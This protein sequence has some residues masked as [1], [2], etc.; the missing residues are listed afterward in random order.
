[1]VISQSAA[2]RFFP[3]EDPVGQ[4][5][6]TGGCTECPWTT[7]VGVVG[8]VKDRGLSNGDTP[9]MYVPFVQEP[10]RSMYL[11]VRTEVEPTSLVPAIRREVNAVDRDLALADIRTMD[12]LVSESL[13]QSRYRVVLLGIFASVALVLA[14]VGIYGVIAYA[15]SQ[16]THEIGIRI[17]LGAQRRDIFGLVIRQGMVM[18]LIGVGLG[19]AASFALTRLLSTLLY[20]VSS[21][22]PFT[23]TAVVLLLVGVALAACSIPAR[24]AMKVDPMESLRYE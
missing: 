6:K 24:R 15:V 19:L 22:D 8:D 5:L 13:G 12:A 10:V 3:T 2:R 16:R 17:A 1:M 14:A 21:T 7:I 18:S 4:R 9:A 20:G 11:V 23:F